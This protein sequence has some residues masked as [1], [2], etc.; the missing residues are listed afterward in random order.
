MSVYPIPVSSFDLLDN[1]VN[2]LIPES[3]LRGGVQVDRIDWEIATGPGYNDSVHAEM[4][5]ECLSRSGASVNTHVIVGTYFEDISGWCEFE[6]KME[7]GYIEKYL[8]LP[9]SAFGS[10]ESKWMDAASS[11][12]FSDWRSE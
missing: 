1:Y 11:L 5:N 3:V 8:L 6:G 12:G 9:K 2:S 7:F 10:I 4:A